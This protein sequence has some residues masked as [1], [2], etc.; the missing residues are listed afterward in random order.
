MNEGPT[1]ILLL[2]ADRDLAADMREAMDE[3]FEARVV[4]ATEVAE[5]PWSEA[6]GFD[7]LVADAACDDPA[8]A[9]Q[10]REAAS[11]G[12]PTI[13]IEPALD[14]ERVLEALRMGVRDVLTRPV[15]YCRLE[16]IVRTAV[17]TRRQSRREADR[18]RRLRATSVRLMR[19]RR[20]LRQRIDLLCKDLVGAYRRLADKVVAAEERVAK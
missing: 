18:Q 2:T 16:Q 3:S 6:P 4:V 19:D 15:D 9:E 11:S 20:E 12:V 10:V 1:R 8:L 14:A 5:A 7:L 13:L 17:E